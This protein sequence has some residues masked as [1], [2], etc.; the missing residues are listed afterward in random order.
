MKI[1]KNSQKGQV[2]HKKIF[3]KKKKK[4]IGSIFL[5][6]RVMVFGIHGKALRSYRIVSL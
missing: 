6:M 5:R 1:I 3:F 2:T 4:V